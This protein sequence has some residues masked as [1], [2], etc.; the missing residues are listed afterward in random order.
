MFLLLGVPLRSTRKRLT[1]LYVGQALEGLAAD[2]P[3]ASSTVLCV[4]QLFAHA[5]SCP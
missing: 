4:P 2:R 5:P 3:S 1:K